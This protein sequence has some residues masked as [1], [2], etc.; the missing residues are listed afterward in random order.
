MPAATR[1]PPSYRLH[2]ATGQG[3]VT[4]N[5]RDVYLGEY[6]TPNSQQ[7]YDRTIA[8]WL[9][10]GRQLL[11]TAADP[12]VTELLAAFLQHDVKPGGAAA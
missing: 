12:Y 11:P 10:N 8:E 3:V 9:A 7:A 5:G 4:L 6:G 2:K 1:K